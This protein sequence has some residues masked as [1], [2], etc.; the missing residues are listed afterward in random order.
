[1]SLREALTQVI[2]ERMEAVSQ[3]MAGHILKERG[4]QPRE[5]V[6]AMAEAMGSLSVGDYAREMENGADQIARSRR[7]V[8]EMNEVL[9]TVR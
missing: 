4:R 1:M 9:I 7:G 5:C 8:P 6:R 2:G 3:A